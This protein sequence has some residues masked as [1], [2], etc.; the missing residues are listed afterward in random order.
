M[1]RQAAL[2]IGILLEMARHDFRARYLGSYLGILWAF[3]HPIVSILVLW[4]IFGL[5]FKTKPVGE[6][7]FV[8]WLAVGMVDLLA[9]F[10]PTSAL[11]RP[12]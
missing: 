5:G 6:V 3:I 11:T 2:K 1:L 8:L 4:V 7:P 12:G 10:S 9:P